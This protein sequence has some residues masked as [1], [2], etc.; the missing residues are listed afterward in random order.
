MNLRGPFEKNADADVSREL[1]GYAAERSMGMEV[2]VAGFSPRRCSS[3]QNTATG[4]PGWAA[5]SSATMFAEF[6]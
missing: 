2:G 4:T 1:I 6:L 3:V 5:A